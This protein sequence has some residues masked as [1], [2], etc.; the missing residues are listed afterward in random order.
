MPVVT[1]LF[2]TPPLE[3]Y[4]M[5]CEL[6]TVPFAAPPE[7]MFRMPSKLR[8]ASFAMPPITCNPSEEFGSE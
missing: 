4:T 2:A 8:M 6:T 5:P 7:T 3:T 1:V